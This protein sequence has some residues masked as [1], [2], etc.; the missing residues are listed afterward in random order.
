M[1]DRPCPP[2][3]SVFIVV[4]GPVPREVGLAR[5]RPSAYF[6]DG[7]GAVSNRAYGEKKILHILIILAILLQTTTGNPATIR[8]VC[9][10]TVMTEP[11]NCTIARGSAASFGSFTIP[12][13]R[14]DFTRY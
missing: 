7:V 2:V 6:Y 8:T 13:R 14:S 1:R 9:K 12:L 11:I 10:L 5:D 3:V 4:R